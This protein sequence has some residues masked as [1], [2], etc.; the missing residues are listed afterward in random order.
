MEPKPHIIRTRDGQQHVVLSLEDFQAL[1]DARH[2]SGNGLVDVAAV[3]RRL[4]GVLSEPTEDVIDL[5]EF[6]ERYDA[7]HAQD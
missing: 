4:S 2:H 5:D 7:V 3:V 1:L 6:L